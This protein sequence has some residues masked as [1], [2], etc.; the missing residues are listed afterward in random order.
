MGIVAAM[1][2]TAALVAAPMAA[3]AGDPIASGNLKFKLSGGFKKQLKRNHVKLTPKKYKIKT[4]STLDPT[5]G[6][7][8]I[9]VGN[10][11]FKKGGKKL[12]FKNSKVTLGASGGRGR[13]SGKAKGTT[14]KIFK[15]KGGTLTRTG[16]GASLSGVK[17]SFQKGAAKK[18]NKA[19]GLH[20]LHKGSA[21]KLTT[22]ENPQT[23]VVTGGFVNVAIP[24]TYLPTV[25]DPSN[26]FQ[27]IP[28]TGTDPNTVAAKS[29]S[30]CI[31][32]FGGSPVIPGNP[33]NPARKTSTSAFDPV[34]G[35]PPA[36]IAALYRFPVTG[37]TIGPAG[38][39]G[40]LQ[41]S[42]GIRLQTGTVGAA[43]GI[44]DGGLPGDCATTAPGVTTSRSFLNTEFND[45]SVS[46]YT[47]T[48]TAVGPNLELQN[49]QSYVTIGGTS[50]GCN[51]GTP[52]NAASP[53]GCTAPLGGAGFKGVSIGQ[54]LDT[55]GQAVS[56]DSAARTVSVSNVVIK[57]NA[58]TSA[59]L[60]QLFPNARGNAARNFADGD[61]FGIS[62]VAVSTR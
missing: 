62:S 53:P 31:S 48:S 46:A 60:N 13:I 2:M 3:G 61:K 6:A 27:P 20:S 44:A 26:G 59:V 47:P 15:L 45:P 23:V 54:I 5:T 52:G 16:F 21:G 50:P 19:L 56:A 14:K 35:A 17:L 55:S 49:V 57:N 18:I 8:L 28:G 34:L 36:G 39:A 33:S 58:V 10:I 7:G 41:L 9:R 22:T 1:A 12:V 42:G 25:L 29:P 51:G 4:G 37:G 24:V 40:S 38:T 32:I 43:D 30:H 11:T